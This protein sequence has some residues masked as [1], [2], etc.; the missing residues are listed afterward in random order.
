MLNR[1]GVPSPGSTWRRE[2]RRKR[3]WVAS[4][5]NCNPARGLGILNNDVYWGV[6]V[7]NRSRWIRS[8][9]DSS[10]RRQVQNPRKEWIVRKDE[11]LRIVSD[12]LWERV[13][14][15]Q[16]ELEHRIGERIKR[17]LTKSAANRT[18]AGPKY[19]ISG[20]LRCGHCGSSFAIAGRDIYKCS[21]HTSGGPALCP[22]DVILRR[23][24]V[25]TEVLAGIKRDLRS[26]EVVEEIALRIRAALRA[27][28]PKPTNDCARIAK[29]RAEVENLAD[30]I[31]SGALRASPT[32]AARLAAAESELDRLTAVQSDL[33]RVVDVTPLLGDLPGRAARAVEE[34]EKTLASGDV[35]RA[36]AQIKAHVG[37]VT[38]EADAREIRLYSDQGAMAAALLR[39]AGGNASLCGSGGVL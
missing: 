37:T 24:V 10:K 22:N 39:T 21:G 20:L 7:W 13:K 9:A 8:A 36:R 6:V 32:I 33:A 1:D 16:G 30:A 28:N 2:S 17:G 35:H 12:E 19:L 26:T 27:R 14:A 38:V 23:T 34:L 3:G 5:I 11:R 15:R 18:G 4:A 31:A 25:E 29:L